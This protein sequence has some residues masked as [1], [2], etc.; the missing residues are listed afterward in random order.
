MSKS[1]SNLRKYA[2]RELSRLEDFVSYKNR[3]YGMPD[4]MIYSVAA[5]PYYSGIMSSEKV[6][7]EPR[8]A[9]EFKRASD[10]FVVASFFQEEKN[11]KLVLIKLS[12]GRE[13][14]LEFAAW[15]VA[16]ERYF[17]YRRDFTIPPYSCEGWR[18]Y[19]LKR[20]RSVDGNFFDIDSL[21][22][23]LKT[24]PPHKK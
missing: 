18:I 11:N 19:D 15:F 23:C 3:I 24:L 22:N 12:T 20:K 9:G 2:P 8:Y 1:K 14:I 17:C 5:F 7:T 6:I 13:I 21:E 16:K 10:E 4:I